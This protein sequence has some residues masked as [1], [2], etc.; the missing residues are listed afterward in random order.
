MALALKLLNVPLFW[1]GEMPV[2]LTYFLYTDWAE[3]NWSHLRAL[4]WS[5]PALTTEKV[6]LFRLNGWLSDAV[7]LPGS[8]KN[9]TLIDGLACW[10]EGR[11]HD[12]SRSI[13]ASPLAKLPGMLC[14]GT[15]A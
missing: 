3:K 2:M 10:M 4:A 12:P 13:A 9:P 11:S 1:L 15:P 8:G 7:L 5:G 14:H 6:R